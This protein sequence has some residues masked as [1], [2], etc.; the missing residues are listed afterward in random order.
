MEEFKTLRKWARL[1]EVL[2]GKPGHSLPWLE[3]VGLSLVVP[4]L[5]LGLHSTDPLCLVSGFPWPAF[6]PLLIGLRHGLYCSLASTAIMGLWA[7]AAWQQDVPA[8]AAFPSAYLVGLLG[9]SLV[10]GEYRAHWERTVSRLDGSE[11]YHRIRLEQFA[12]TYHILKT[13]HDNLEQQISASTRSLRGALSDLQKYVFALDPASEGALKGAAGGILQLFCDYGTLQIAA[14]WEIREDG[15]LADRAAAK[16]GMPRPLEREDPI[17]KAALESRRAVAFAPGTLAQGGGILAAV[18][19]VD[20]AGRVHGVVTIDEL[21]FVALRTA[22]LNLLSVLGGYVADFLSRCPGVCA[23]GSTN[24]SQIFHEAV[25]RAVMDARHYR[26]PAM[27]LG[28]SLSVDYA[29]PEFIDKVVLNCRGLDRVWVADR[30]SQGVVIVKLMPCTDPVGAERYI[31]RLDRML[32]TQW[33]VPL[34]A[35]GIGILI[36]S[37]DGTSDADQVLAKF[38]RLIKPEWPQTNMAAP[39]AE[40]ACVSRGAKC[41]TYSL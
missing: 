24:A 3:T 31:W 13:S 40:V 28:L 29:R 32:K 1:S 12:K 27:L 23:A 36:E 4:A 8:G 37:V 16:V 9:L 35:D 2:S 30:G 6:I 34:S 22:N 26:V 41:S 25:R 17:L 33:G 7:L 15:S 11:R 14:L 38:K 20:I 10:S 18:P 39:R 5:G 19:I 21:P